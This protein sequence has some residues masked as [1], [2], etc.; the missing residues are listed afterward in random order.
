MTENT[1]QGW[2]DMASAPKDGEF[3]A[4]LVSE[5][6]KVKRAVC[7]TRE[8]GIYTDGCDISNAWTPVGWLPLPTD[9]GFADSL[10]VS[11]ELERVKAQRNA[12][13]EHIEVLL[14]EDPNAAS[15]AP[16]ATILDQ[17]RHDAIH[18]LGV[19]RAVTRSQKGQTND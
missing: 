1:L 16:G 3:L 13:A 12:L 6:G 9:T 10:V 4:K 15:D 2:R 17:W 19:G 14:E 5:S 18:R 7:E 11:E 8:D